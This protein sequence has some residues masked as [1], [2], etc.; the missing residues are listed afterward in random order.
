MSR[1]YNTV[2]TDDAGKF[3]CTYR[4]DTSLVS[5]L[6][7]LSPIKRLKRKRRRRVDIGPQRGQKAFQIRLLSNTIS[8][9]LVTCTRKKHTLA[10]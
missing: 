2:R 6:W 7:I 4:L 10:H 9:A 8:D 1:F 3:R 5:S